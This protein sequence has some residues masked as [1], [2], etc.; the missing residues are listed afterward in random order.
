MAPPPEDH[1]HPILHNVFMALGLIV[2]V[3]LGAIV[4][5]S[6]LQHRSPTDVVAR[7]VA[8]FIMEPPQAHFHEDRIALLLLGIDYN[9]ISSASCRG[10]D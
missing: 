5:Q 3:L 7:D 6:I 1:H 4:T 9:W 2:G 10:Y 8:P